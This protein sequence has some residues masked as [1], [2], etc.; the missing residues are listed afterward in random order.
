MN[1][2]TSD[3]LQAIFRAVFELPSDQPV[4]RMEQANFPAWDSLAHVSLV[5]GIES[6]FDVSLDVAD[7][8]RMTS[9]AETE[10][11]LRDLGK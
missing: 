6:E 3:R 9:Y 1:T 4:S 8:L 7:Q 2:E 11:L 5:T 10:R